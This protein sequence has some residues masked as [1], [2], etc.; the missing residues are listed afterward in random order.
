MD[1]WICIYNNVASEHDLKKTNRIFFWFGNE[2]FCHCFDFSKKLDW[3]FLVV[4][5][6]IM[7]ITTL[8]ISFQLVENSTILTHENLKLVKL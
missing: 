4:M 7:N 6:N 1:E 8:F 3:K 5:N 2:T